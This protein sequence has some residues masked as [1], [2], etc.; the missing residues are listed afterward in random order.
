[1]IIDD[2]HLK[3]IAVMPFKAD[4]P[5]LLMLI[6]YCSYAHSPKWPSSADAVL[7]LLWQTISNYIEVNY[8]L[9]TK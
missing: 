2:G 1:M 7:I 6:A 3:C 9:N 5:L 4:P 8:C